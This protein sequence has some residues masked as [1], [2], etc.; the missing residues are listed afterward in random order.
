[1]PNINTTTGTSSPSQ[2]IVFNC[3]GAGT[4]VINGLQ[5]P[6]SSTT[7][8]I[9]PAY[10]GMY[11]CE[12]GKKYMDRT[13]IWKH[14]KK[15]AIYI[16]MHEHSSSSTS[17]DNLHD[18]SSNEDDTYD[19][20]DDYD[21]PDSEVVQH[22]QDNTLIH[23]FCDR[24]H[25]SNMNT[26]SKITTTTPDSKPSLYSQPFKQQKQPQQEKEHAQKQTQ[27]YNTTHTATSDATATTNDDPDTTSKVS[28][29]DLTPEIIT[30]M[31]RIIREQHEL[32]KELIPK[33]GNNITNNTNN[34]QF[35]LNFFLNEECKDA[36][37]LSDFVNSLEISMDDLDVTKSQ[38]LV[39]SISTVLVNGLKQLDVYK[40]PIHCTDQK[41]DTIYIKDN[42][43]W[44]R[45]EGN[46]RIKKVF[47]DIANKEYKAIKTW[48]DSNPG[49]ENNTRLQD[50][51]HTMLLNVLHEIKD[52]PV[53][54]R[55][56]L[57]CLEQAVFIEK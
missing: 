34:T 2:S 32:L 50:I 46:I 11:I 27:G 22:E 51:H 4:V 29:K 26:S 42:H 21:I 43:K 16:Q 14:K 57:K 5:I 45:D 55:K 9:A 38:G 18:T 40:R 37:N 44:Q 20:N 10:N 49:W 12:C 56:I 8:H 33:V 39:S 35:N 28:V 24:K 3:N 7:T 13:G 23:T 36:I 25:H 30:D 53:G 6:P 15:C 52:D 41:R 17:S 54:E 48:M 47:V 31:L 19:D 1:M